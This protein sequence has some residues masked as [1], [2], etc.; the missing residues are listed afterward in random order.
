MVK[1]ALFT[2]LFEEF[3]RNSE[4][5]RRLKRD[6][7]RLSQSTVDSYRAVLKNILLF[8]QLHNDKLENPIRLTM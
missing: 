2:A 6:G 5:G 7:R 3:L 8:E 1:N 4:R